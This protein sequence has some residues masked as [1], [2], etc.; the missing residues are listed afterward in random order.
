MRSRL[1]LSQLPPERIS[2][3]EMQ[4]KPAVFQRRVLQQPLTI[5]SNGEPTIVAM[6]VAEYRRLQGHTAA[7]S[8]P[9]QTAPRA[10]AAVMDR[11]RAIGI[12]RD[13]RRSLEARGIAHASIFGSVARGEAKTTSDIDIAVKPMPG[14]RLD[15]IDLGGVQTV[16]DE[17]FEG[18]DVDVV[19]E[20]MSRPSLQQAI[21]Q[22]RVNAF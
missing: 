22:D 5:T 18:I 16:L 19:V 9:P 10:Y 3:F 4:R 21:H 8:G 13:L 14:R 12:L 7:D 11:D 17:G 6:S 15:L 1:D 2:A 20:P